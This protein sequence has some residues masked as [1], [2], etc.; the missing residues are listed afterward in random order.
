MIRGDLITVREMSVLIRLDM[1]HAGIMRP[2]ATRL[3]TQDMTCM[4]SVVFHLCAQS[5]NYKHSP[6]YFIKPKGNLTF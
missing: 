2:I 3:H 4:E 1:V 5:L 6:K